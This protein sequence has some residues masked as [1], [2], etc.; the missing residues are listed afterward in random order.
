MSHQ[1]QHQHAGGG[2]GFA[3]FFQL[4]NPEIILLTILIAAAYLL[5]VG[6]LRSR[7]QDATPATAKQ[8]ACFL[9]GLVFFYVAQGSPINYYGHHYLF[10]A[11]MVQQS[12]LYLAMP[13]LLLIG[14]PEWLLQL[15][16]K[17]HIAKKLLTFFTNPL[18][19]V[20][21]FNLLFSFYHYPFVFDLMAE[22]HQW[23]TLYH[24]VLIFAAFQMWWPIVSPLTE[25]KQLSDL[26]KIAYIFAN[27]VLITPA[28][29]LIIFSDTVLYATYANAPEIFPGHTVFHD[30]RL[31]GVMMKLIQEGVYGSVLA[32][33]F[34]KWYNKEKGT[35]I[36]LPDNAR[37]QMGILGGRD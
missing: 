22:H 28:C 35:D 11:H 17:N 27:G 10:S 37:P 4:W 12:L 32:Y 21:S 3:N 18:I 8:K 34:Y 23:M 24:I 14:T 16:F 33:T 13:P 6:P 26:R 29:A 20:L 15:L 30:Q 2:D 5:A 31:G 25:Q 36:E 9:L 7:F 1:Q 19:G